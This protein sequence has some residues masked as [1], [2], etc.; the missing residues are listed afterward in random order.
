MQTRSSLATMAAIAVMATSLVASDALGQRAG[1]SM[2]VQTG[3]VVSSQAVNMQSRA[4]RG[5]L[6]GGVV[7]Y[8]TTSGRHSSSRL[9][10]W[11]RRT[12]RMARSRIPFRVSA[13]GSANSALAS[14]SESMGV[15][16][17][18]EPSRGRFTPLTGL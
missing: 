4:G 5:A 7:G 10:P 15:C 11:Y 6:V 9:S 12:E 3:V 16:P 1:Q 8:A 14:S 17:S 2:T 13:G 18:F